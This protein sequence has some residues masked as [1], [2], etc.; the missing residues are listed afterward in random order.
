MHEHSFHN[1]AS[2]PPASQP[3]AP[4]CVTFQRLSFCPSNGLKWRK[5]ISIVTLKSVP[6]AGE[7]SGREEFDFSARDN[8]CAV[9]VKNVTTRQKCVHVFVCMFKILPGSR[10]YI[11]FPLVFSFFSHCWPSCRCCGEIVLSASTD[12]FSHFFG[13]TIFAAVLAAIFSLLLWFF[14]SCLLGPVFFWGELVGQFIAPAANVCWM[15]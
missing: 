12:P 7:V 3:P 14:G 1:P 2:S 4:L 10:N 11:F 13:T 15:L 5:E 8:R 6:L 9:N